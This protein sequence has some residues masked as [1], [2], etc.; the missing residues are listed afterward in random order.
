MYITQRERHDELL[1]F[2]SLAF[3]SDSPAQVFPRLKESNFSSLVE[4]S[5]GP[6]L[7][8]KIT[9]KMD[10]IASSDEVRIFQI[11]GFDL[12]STS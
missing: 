10:L 12:N 1:E 2:V 8:D 7:S 5:A 11:R 6:R 9:E 3:S 4:F